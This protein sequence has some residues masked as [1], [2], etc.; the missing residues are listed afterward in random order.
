MK[1]NQ[2]ELLASQARQN[3]ERQPKTIRRGTQDR[4]REDKDLVKNRVGGFRIPFFPRPT[5]SKK[6]QK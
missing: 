4:Q 3:D 5:T 2:K 6:E 1:E